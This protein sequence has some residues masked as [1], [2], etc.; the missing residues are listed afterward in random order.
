MVGVVDVLTE[1]TVAPH[2]GFGGVVSD[3]VGEV[4]V[5]GVVV[6]VG[7]VIGVV[8]VVTLVTVVV[9]TVVVGGAHG[10]EVLVVGVPG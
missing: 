8:I 6:V 3:D 4:V 1:V 10:R 7:V 5:A 9:V 2:G